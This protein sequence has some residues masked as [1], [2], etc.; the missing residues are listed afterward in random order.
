MRGFLKAGFKGRTLKAEVLSF[1]KPERPCGPPLLTKHQQ[2][3][4]LFCV[5]QL[6]G[7][8]TKMGTAF[9]LSYCMAPVCLAMGLAAVIMEQEPIISCPQ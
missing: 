6:T 9:F 8:N 4:H 5:L 2:S 7:K 1:P 3:R